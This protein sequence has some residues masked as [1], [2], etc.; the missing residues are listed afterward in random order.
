MNRE[1]L[2]EFLQNMWCALNCATTNDEQFEIMTL[3]EKHGGKGLPKWQSY[4]EKKQD[5]FKESMKEMDKLL[6]NN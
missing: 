4:V 3:M 1:Q 5:I 2:Q 6:K